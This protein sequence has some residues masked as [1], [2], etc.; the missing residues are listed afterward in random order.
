MQSNNIKS[1]SDPAK[2]KMFS[3]S[4]SLLIGNKNYVGSHW[5]RGTQAKSIRQK[6]GIGN[7]YYSRKN[8]KYDVGRQ[9]VLRRKISGGPRTPQDSELAANP[10]AMHRHLPGDVRRRPDVDYMF[11]PRVDKVEGSW[12]KRGR[13]QVHH[14]GGKT[15]TFVC[16]RCGYPVKSKLQVIKDENWDWRM[17]YSCYVSVVQQGMEDRT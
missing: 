15:E 14:V 10:T 17:C 5:M 9:H 1:E 13:F 4:T 2:K 8:F 16:F 3:F 6:F 12:K 11:E 7:Q